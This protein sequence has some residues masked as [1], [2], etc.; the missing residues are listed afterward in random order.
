MPPLFPLV[1]AFFAVAVTLCFVTLAQPQP[2]PASG[3]WRDRLIWPLLL[4]G[5]LAQAFDIAWLCLHG[6]HPGS[7]AREAI[8]FA[9]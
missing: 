7:S 1:L 9:S 6:Q 5:V 3:R 4:L 8:Y 2:I